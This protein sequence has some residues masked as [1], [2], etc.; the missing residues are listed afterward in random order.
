MENGL[1]DLSLLL[2]DQ[3]PAAVLAEVK[4]IV[5]QVAPGLDT[6]PLEAVHAGTVDLFTG[7]FPG[8]RE[9][10]NA[11]HD[12]DHTM[13]V[14]LGMARL[15]HG[16]ILSGI[17]ISERGVIL[18]LISALFH[19][20]GFIQTVDDT[21]GTGAKYT[22]VHEER[23][24]D[25]ASSYLTE[26]GFKNFNEDDVQVIEA[27]LMCT[28]LRV[29]MT[30]INYPQ[31]EAHLLGQLLGTADLLGQMADRW[32]LMKLPSLYIEFKEADIGGYKD[33]LD[34]LDKT[35]GFWGFIQKRLDGVL[36]G[37]R[38]VARLHF[39]ERFGVDRDLYHESIELQIAY[40]RDVLENHR[41]DYK[42]RLSREGLLKYLWKI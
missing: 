34:L 1:Q 11:Y 14:F 23:G 19:D 37:M 41:K 9:S 2:D 30:K 28:S 4:K 8:Y 39:K 6:G 32:Y 15:I 22:T 20:I 3:T 5:K 26:G 13:H 31:D 36:G 21:E 33:E 38:K 24:V 16:T 25:F 17:A 40:L 27:M 7:K 18:G 29:D 10:T 12:L 42:K 35:I